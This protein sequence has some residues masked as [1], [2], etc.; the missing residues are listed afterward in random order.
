MSAPY[1]VG[2][3][4]RVLHSC[5]GATEIATL[6]VTHIKALA[7]NGR[8]RVTT[9]RCNGTPLEVEV[10]SDGRDEHGYVRRGGVA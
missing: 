2:D 8:W 9:V 1:R 5:D 6:T 7:T 10:G 4:M 3:P